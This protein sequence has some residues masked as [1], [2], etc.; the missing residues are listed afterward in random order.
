MS[1]HRAL[2]STIMPARPRASITSASITR[3]STGSTSSPKRAPTRIAYEAGTVEV[4]EHHDG[5][6]LVLKKIAA[7]Y[8]PHDRVAAMTFLQRNAEIGQMTRVI[9]RAHTRHPGCLCAPGAC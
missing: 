7:D 8:D 3:P 6:K 9:A 5:S 1:F 2:R 4:V